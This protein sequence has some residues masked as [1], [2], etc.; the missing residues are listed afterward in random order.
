VCFALTAAALI[1]T[2]NSPAAGYESSI[3]QATP[4]IFWVAFAISITCGIAIIIHQLYIKNEEHNGW[5]VGLVLILVSYTAILSLLI[6]RGY[7]LWNATG[8]DSSHLGMVQTIIATGH[9]GNTN[10]YPIAHIYAAEISSICSIAPVVLHKGMPLT[11]ALLYVA[12]M[13]LLAKAVLPHKGA[14][15]LATLASLTLLYGSYLR[16]MPNVLANL[17]FPLALFLVIKSFTSSSW[18]WQW[19][20]I[21]MVLLFPVFHPVPTVALAVVLVAATLAKVVLDKVTKNTRRIADSGVKFSLIALAILL[22]WGGGWISSY[23][24]VSVGVARM[25]IPESYSIPE[26][27]LSESTLSES[28]LSESTLSESTLL[29]KGYP[30]PEPYTLETAPDLPRVSGN[31]P[32]FVRLIDDIRHGQEYGYSAPEAFFKIYGGIL[33]YILLALIAFP[34][35]WRR[36]RKQANLRNL[37]LLYGP[38]AAIALLIVGLYFTGLDFGPLRFLPYIPLICTIFVGYVGYELIERAGISKRSSRV[39]VLAPILVGIVLLGAFGSGAANLYASPYNLNDNYQTTRTE[40]VGMDWLF[41]N[42]AYSLA[43]SD[44]CLPPGRFADFLLTPEERSWRRDIP[45]LDGIQPPS[46]FG[47]HKQTW[48][49]GWYL[50]DAYLVLGER[51]KLRYVEVY[52]KLAKYRFYPE[53]FER[54]NSD[55]T[56]DKLY[57]NGECDIWLIHSVLSK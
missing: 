2:R 22:I 5:K 14:V 49:G 21:V 47:Y 48:L 51:D 1:V 26:S 27:T 34:I 29:I 41:D 24:N 6:V 19:L 3:Y 33:L 50:K 30:R 44:H 18:R 10:F 55:P 8:D 53:D 12:F 42:K 57:T 56:L 25:L 15:I 46:H 20:L 35:L 11:L 54:L 39:R 9:I 45:W 40:I 4:L 23:S 17:L 13:Y 31:V 16:F 36:L 28:T 7:A 38:L 32:N 37:V 43:I 52:P